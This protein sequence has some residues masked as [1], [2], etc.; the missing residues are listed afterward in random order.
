MRRLVA[1]FGG[2]NFITLESSPRT[3][4]RDKLGNMPIAP[5]FGSFS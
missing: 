5:N 3:R 1:F 4:P 2:V